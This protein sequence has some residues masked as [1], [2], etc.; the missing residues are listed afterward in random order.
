MPRRPPIGWQPSREGV[1]P[2]SVPP[3]LTFEVQAKLSVAFRLGAFP[4]QAAAYSGISRSTLYR[5][6]AAARQPGAHPRLKDFLS[7][8]ERAEAEAAVEAVKTIHRAGLAGQWRA[9]GWLLERLEPEA[10]G[11]VDRFGRRPTNPPPS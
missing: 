2:G 1:A 4:E 10:F 6:R 9:S 3:R 5:W 11:P 8:I 7:E